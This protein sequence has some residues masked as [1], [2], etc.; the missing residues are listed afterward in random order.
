MKNFVRLGVLPD[1][2]TIQALGSIQADHW[3]ADTYIRHFPQGPF[4]DTESIILRFPTR[5]VHETQEALAEHLRHWDQHENYWLPIADEL[6]LLKRLIFNLARNMEASR[7]GRCIVNKMQPGGRIYRHADSPDHAAYW[8]RHHIVLHAWSGN[9]FHCGDEV[10]NMLTN[11]I[12]W[13]NNL[14]EHEVHNNSNDYRIHLVV[15][16]KTAFK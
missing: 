7:I 16:L 11:E 4:G 8:S 15:D 1:Q 2:E 5:S 14:L 9:D 6:P 10:V 13:F 12:W 3:Q